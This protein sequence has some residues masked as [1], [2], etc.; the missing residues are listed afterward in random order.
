MYKVPPAER[1]LSLWQAERE[2]MKSEWSQQIDALLLACPGGAVAAEEQHGDLSDCGCKN[3][4]RHNSF[5]PSAQF[6]TK[7]RSRQAR[8]GVTH[9]KDRSSYIFSGE[10]GIVG[11]A[12]WSSGDPF[13]SQTTPCN[14]ALE[15]YAVPLLDPLP[16][17]YANGVQESENLGYALLA[18]TTQ[19]TKL[20]TGGYRMYFGT[21]SINQVASNPGG[22]RAWPA[23]DA[24]G[25]AK[26]ALDPVGV[27]Y[28]SFHPSQLQ[29]WGASNDADYSTAHFS[30]NFVGYL[31][32]T[33]G[34]NYPLYAPM[35]RP[36]SGTTCEDVSYVG[37]SGILEDT[38]TNFWAG[39]RSTSIPASGAAVVYR[40]VS[41]V[42]LKSLNRYFMFAVECDGRGLGVDS[43]GLGTGADVEEG[44]G[45]TICTPS[46]KPFPDWC[47]L[48]NQPKTRFVYFTC[49]DPDFGANTKGPFPV[50]PEDPDYSAGAWI[51]VPQAFM[52]PDEKYILFYLNSSLYVGRSGYRYSGLHVA[53]VSDLSANIA[54]IEATAATSSASDLGTLFYKNFI[55]FG[56]CIIECTTPTTNFAPTVTDEHF[57][58]CSDGRLHLFFANRD[59]NV[60][61]DPLRLISH[62]AAFSAWDSKAIDVLF[63][64]APTVSAGTHPSILTDST[65]YQF[66]PYQFQLP[67]SV[68]HLNLEFLQHI[69]LHGQVSETAPTTPT[70]MLVNFRMT[71][72][73]PID[74]TDALGTDSVNIPDDVA[75]N[76][77]NVY[78]ADS[79]DYVMI[80]HCGVLGGLVRLTADV[81]T[82]CS[83]RDAC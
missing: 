73:N 15:D 30:P 26:F 70:D 59:S 34:I 28:A 38:S 1:L 64:E 78:E 35:V 2:R 55:N 46:N 79:G 3:T 58:F 27:P 31:D 61:A 42:Y 6:R 83:Y 71:D 80:L 72:C 45:C 8:G 11:M 54:H 62:A 33:D 50:Y 16:C 7:G 47:V 69:H 81:A 12:M 13:P 76:D 22:S 74:M 68:P 19:T 44:Q 82:A 24:G 48:N 41:V 9:N 36:S 77:P 65:L 18:G 29:F 37:T 5:A 43:N 75:V 23:Y 17:T 39:W 10:E 66:Q 67:N 60:I 25:R 51:G 21:A 20:P 52:S 4:Q 40:D 14:W 56:V 53:R 32:S 49:L 57:V 63:G